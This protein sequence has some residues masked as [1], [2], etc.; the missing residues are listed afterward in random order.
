VKVGTEHCSVPTQNLKAACILFYH[1]GNF[2]SFLNDG[3]SPQVIAEGDFLGI[4]AAFLLPALPTGETEKIK[5]I[6]LLLD[7]VWYMY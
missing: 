4:K 5:I 6:I 7:L 3:K 1:L 2:Y